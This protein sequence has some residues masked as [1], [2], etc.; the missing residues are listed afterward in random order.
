MSLR[1]AKFERDDTAGGSRQSLRSTA[2]NCSPSSLAVKHRDRFIHVGHHDCEVLKRSAVSRRNDKWPGRIFKKL[3]ALPTQNERSRRG[4]LVN[5]A[6]EC[7]AIELQHC[8]D[9]LAGKPDG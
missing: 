1:V 5:L 9:V 4:L 7:S 2:R 6:S 3:N 8:A